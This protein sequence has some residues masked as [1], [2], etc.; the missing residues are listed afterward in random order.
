M[1][2]YW[3]SAVRTELDLGGATFVDLLKQAPLNEA[4]LQAA[5]DALAQHVE[6]ARAR[7]QG[8][9]RTS[10]PPPETADD[11]ILRRAT[12]IPFD[13]PSSEE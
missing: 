7:L 4:A 2:E 8:R 6:G 13:S 12:G 9:L 3:V 5:M 1:A 10:V 11:R